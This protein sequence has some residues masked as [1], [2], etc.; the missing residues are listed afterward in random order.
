MSL[1]TL[2]AQQQ[3]DLM[4]RG[5]DELLVEAEMLAK[6]KKSMASG[7]PL[8]AK[9]G[10]DPTRPDL[11]LGHSVVLNKLRQ[12]QD[13][14]HT[15]IFLVGDF[16]SLI[17]DPSGRNDTR[18]PL[19]R[20]QIIENAKTYHAQASKVLDPAKTEIRY[21]S[22]WS[23]P[24]GAAGMIKL[25]SRYTVARMMEREDFTQ[26]FKK[27]VPIAIHEFLYPLM[28]GYDSV[29][30]HADIELG[31]TDQKFN[32]LMGRTLQ[33]Q[34]GQEPQCILTM[35]LLVGLDGVEKMSKSK[36]NY[37]GLTEPASEIFGKV[38]SIS[39]EL[40]WNYYELV[41]FKPQ[42]E[43]TAMK[44]RCDGKQMNPRDAKVALAVEIAAR[45]SSQAD[46]ERAHAEFEARKSGAAP[47]QMP[48]MTLHCAED[49]MLATQVAKQADLVGS[50]SEAA[51]LIEGRGFKVDGELI[52]DRH[53]KLAKGKTYVIQA[54]KRKFARVTLV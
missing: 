29:A 38:M 21:N 31:G 35:P 25:A 42:A 39:D 51:R 54:G 47:E 37:I 41:S 12:F 11:H 36:D 10:L 46:A 52:E 9:L 7:K 26:R 50:T 34:Y 18:P 30:L 33:S 2:S 44:A 6:I 13:I 27:G 40:M 22:E 19:D 45:F 5:C 4:K 23:D 49:T 14:G 32:L 8:R 28:Q 1:V 48:E 15:V 16:T 24:L 17:G 53:V 43:I 3:L 20:E